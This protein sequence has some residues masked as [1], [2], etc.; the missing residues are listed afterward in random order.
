MYRGGGLLESLH[1]SVPE[2]LLLAAAL[3]TRFGD[4]WVLLSITIA[5]SWLLT[6]RGND[7]GSGHRTSTAG[8]EHAAVSDATPGLT[9]RVPAVWLV[10]VVVGGLAAMTALKYLFVLPRPELVAATPAALPAALEPTYISTV[11]LGG[12]GFPSGHA[13]GA[14]VAYGLLALTVR[15]G[16]RRVRFAAAGV[17]ILAISLSR[18]VLAVHY[19]GDIVAGIV[20]GVVYL[21]AVLWL[22]ER[23][24]FD[25]TT[26]AFALALGLALLAMVASG[27][28]GRSVTYAAL[29]A[30]ALA[31]WSIARPQLRSSSPP[32]STTASRSRSTPQ[33][34]YHTESATVALAL[35]AGI[36]ALEG[37]V[38]AVVPAAALGV[39]VVVPAVAVAR[40][41][42]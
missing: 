29:A 41:P 17:F 31:A 42:S 7:G 34:A 15:T 25:R 21:A 4:V 6:W 10:G 22:L 30:G 3:V 11:T 2:W 5:A 18:V 33:P 37:S 9:P 36:T 12:Y 14:T 28:A 38:E 23:S 35:L 40:R 8:R 24:P 32:S 13:L 26:T 16:T 20:L 1:G 39:L 27:S 19:P